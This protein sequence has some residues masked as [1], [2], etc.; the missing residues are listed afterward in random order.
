MVKSCLVVRAE[1]TGKANRDRF[2]RW[3]ATDHL[4]LAIKTLRRGGPGAAGAPPIRRSTMLFMN[5]TIRS[6][7]K[8]RPRPT[9]LSR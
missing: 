3:Y 2:D 8:L 1:V 6:R 9:G 5:S 7:R 4:P